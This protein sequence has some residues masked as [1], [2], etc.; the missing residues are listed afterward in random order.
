MSGDAT[1]G[2]LHS[3]LIGRPSFVKKV[4]LLTKLRNLRR[5]MRVYKNWTHVVRSVRENRYPIDSVLRNGTKVVLHGYAEALLRSYGRDVKY[6]PELD[7][8]QFSWNGHTVHL[9]GINKYTDI[10]IT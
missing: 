6:E 4:G 1:D 10:T 8:I 9:K 2:A 3:P 7:R 5:Y